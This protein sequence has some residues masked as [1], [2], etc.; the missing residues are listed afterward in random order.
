MFLII[1]YYY[2]YYY[3][4]YYYVFPEFVAVYLVFKEYGSFK[5]PSTSYCTEKNFINTRLV[6]LVTCRLTW[7][8]APRG[9]LNG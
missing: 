7:S 4:C 2:Y 3:Y 8:I 1:L 9:E 5:W 6:F